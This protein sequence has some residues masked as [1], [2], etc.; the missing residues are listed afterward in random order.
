MPLGAFLAAPD[1]MRCLSEN[2]PLS[3]VTTFG[4]HPVC[5][6]AGLA[7]LE[8]LAEERLPERAAALGSRI[9]TAFWSLRELYGGIVAVRGKGLLIGVEL[10]SAERTRRLVEHAF[11]HGLILGWTLHTE[12]VIRVAPPLVLTEEELTEGLALF[13]AALAA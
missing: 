5:C 8:V 1:V 4:G 6:A 13:E 12:T 2:P 10:D 9:R 11:R 3:H 7:G